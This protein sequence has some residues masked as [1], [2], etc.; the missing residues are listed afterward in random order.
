MLLVELREPA[1]FQHPSRICQG[2]SVTTADEIETVM[3]LL[4]WRSD[5]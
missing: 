2:L 1:D 3:G 4:L 5:R